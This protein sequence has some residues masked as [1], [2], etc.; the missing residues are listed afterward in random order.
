M[1][2]PN[3]R[4]DDLQFNNLFIIQNKDG[5]CFTSDA[6]A[7]ANFVRGGVKDTMVDLCS[8]SGIIGILAQAKINAKHVYLVELQSSLANMSERSVEYNKLNNVTV[9]NK[10]LQNIHKTIGSNFE[11]VVCNPPYKIDKTG[12]V[13]ENKEIAICKNELAVT[14]DEIVKEASSL[15]KFG[16]RFYTCNKEDRLVDLLVSMR[17]YK[18]EPKVIK[19]LKSEK[20]ASIVLVEG[21]KGGKAGVK[22]QF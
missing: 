22:I 3:E 13:S 21:K 12:G 15:L 10:P 17:N 9:I 1:I 14:L 5:Y 19:F 16:G 4:L 18:I 8:G 11:I 20:G 6:V 7:L 2:K